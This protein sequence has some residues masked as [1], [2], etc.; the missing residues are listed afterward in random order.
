MSDIQFYF[1]PPQL[2]VVNDPTPKILL[3]AGRGFGKSHMIRQKAVLD[4]ITCPH[5]FQPWEQKPV[6]SILGQHNTQLAQIHWN[7]LKAQCETI[8]APLVKD[9]HTFEKRISWQ[10]NKPDLILRGLGTGT[11][12][13]NL[14]GL[15]FYRTY[16]DEA[17]DVAL[18]DLLDTIIAPR[19]EYPGSQ[20]MAI[21]TP[22]GFS[23]DTYT[24]AQRFS[25]SG[26][27]VEYHF[28][29]YDNPFR[30]ARQLDEL[31]R[32]LPTRQFNQEIMALY[33]NFENQI[34]SEFSPSR[35]IKSMEP[36]YLCYYLSLDNGSRNPAI[37]TLGLYRRPDGYL[38]LDVLPGTFYNETRECVTV[39]DIVSAV[40]TRMCPG[41]FRVFVPDD[42]ADIAFSIRQRLPDAPV[43]I[44]TRS[45]PS[46]RARQD[47][48]NTAFKVGALNVV[49]STQDKVVKNILSYHRKTTSRG[50]V[51]EQ[52]DEACEDHDIDAIMYAVGQIIAPEPI[53]FGLLGVEGVPVEPLSNT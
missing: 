39:D 12:G 23:N 28:T 14:R 50:M 22:K 21:F 2:R 35:S 41:V 7:V 16:V 51:L 6:V 13:D 20:F 5:T 1:T 8:Y 27:G 45:K 42:R 25:R 34:F 31:R 38:T 44:I 33:E 18:I 53:K 36:E 10:G 30:D 32:T 48:T 46:V 15:S 19:M 29:S 26:D 11:M 47:I 37:V 43:Q 52:A 17:Q 24:L 4:C 40:A 49:G 3:R 9:I